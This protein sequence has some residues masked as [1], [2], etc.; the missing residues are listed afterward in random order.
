LITRRAFTFGSIPLLA[1]GAEPGFQLTDV[2]A[3]AGISFRHNSG[4]FG[5]KH[6]PETMRPGCAFLDYDGDGWLDI[7]LVN[8]MDWPGHKRQRSTPKLYKNNRIGTFKDVTQDAGLTAELYGIAVA[9]GDY[10]NDGFPDVLITA[11]GQN[12]LFKNTGKGHFLDVTEKAGLAGRTGFSTSAMWFDYDRDGFLDLFICNY[13]K[14]SPEHDVFCSV[15]GKNKSSP[16]SRSI[17][18]Q[19]QSL[20]SICHA[21]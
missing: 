13:V 4:A 17:P 12:R 8:G 2:T 19:R 7:L 11:V 15:D 21:R 1:L 18:G 5:A 9:A 3:A 6:L 20:Y 14:W 16:Y 10:N